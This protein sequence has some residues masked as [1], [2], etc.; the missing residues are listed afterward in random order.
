[1][2]TITTVVLILSVSILLSCDKTEDFVDPSDQ[3]LYG[4][5][6]NPTSDNE[7]NVWTYEKS[8][9]LPKNNWGLNFKADKTVVERKNSGW[10][11]T[12]PIAYGDFPGKWN[13]TDS[14]ISFSVGYWG[15]TVDRQ[16]KII[17][18]SNKYLKISKLK[19]EYQDDF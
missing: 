13:L 19:E 4:F 7:N 15:G 6:V 1:M 2:K 14:I 8:T 9:E 12:P 17:S 3:N 10:C 18:I 16:W 5:W 11:G